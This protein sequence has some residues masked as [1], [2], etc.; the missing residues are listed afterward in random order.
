MTKSSYSPCVLMVIIYSSFKSTNLFILLTLDLKPF[1][2]SELSA[3][4]AKPEVRIDAIDKA[5]GRL[6]S[7]TRKLNPIVQ[8]GM[9]ALMHAAF[10]GNVEACEM[11]VTSRADV[12]CNLQTDCVRAVVA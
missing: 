6:S 7:V 10:K 12:N 1:P 11:L 9:S 3:L 5:R 4:L 8:D 2:R